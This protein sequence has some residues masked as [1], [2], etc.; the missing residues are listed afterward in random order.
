MLRWLTTVHRDQSVL[1]V[2]SPTAVYTRRPGNHLDRYVRN[3]MMTRASLDQ[4]YTFV[5]REA[6]LRLVAAMK[7]RSG[8]RGAQCLHPTPSLCYQR[9]AVRTRTEYLMRKTEFFAQRAAEEGAVHPLSAT[10]SRPARK[11][12]E[13][14]EIRR[15][16]QEEGAGGA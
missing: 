16:M 5:D 3:A 15:L 11:W 14:E 10:I 1:R 6:K 2:A 4:S 9:V 13:T 7:R 12:R 8:A